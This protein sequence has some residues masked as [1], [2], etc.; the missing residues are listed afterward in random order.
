MKTKTKEKTMTKETT[1]TEMKEKTMDGFLRFWDEKGKSVN[2]TFLIPASKKK[3]EQ[4]YAQISFD[5]RFSKA[6]DTLGVVLTLGDTGK[7]MYIGAS[8]E[9]LGRVFITK[10]K[11]KKEQGSKR[12]ATIL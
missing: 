10:P 3:G 9:K 11:E 1:K 5:V 2:N 12:E 6:K 8:N 7:E 4:A